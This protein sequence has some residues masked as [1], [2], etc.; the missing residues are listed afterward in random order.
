MT[1]LAVDVFGLD[2]R[3]GSNTYVLRADD[4]A[5]EA[6]VVDPGGDPAPLLENLGDRGIAVSAIL[7]THA[8]VDHIGGVAALAAATGTEVWIPAGEA[9][10]LREGVTRGGTPVEAH[11]PEHE[12]RAGDRFTAAGIELEVAAVPGHSA[13]HV[14]FVAGDEIFSGDL[15]FAGS[16]GRVDLPGGDWDTLLASVKG[17]LERYGADAVVYP[18]HGGPTTLGRELASNPFLGELRS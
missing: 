17:L 10:H 16:V 2:Q 6:V 12:V 11:T 9:H 3:Y 7:V 15:L 18:G 1:R 13:D 4:N 5:S 14:A 8:D